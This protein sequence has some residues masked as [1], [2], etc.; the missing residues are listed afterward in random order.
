M[1]LAILAMCTGL[2]IAIDRLILAPM[3]FKDEDK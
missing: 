1:E 2:A 3:F